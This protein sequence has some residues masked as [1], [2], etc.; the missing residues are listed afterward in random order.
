[1]STSLG[2][3]H[4]STIHCRLCDASDLLS[5]W[6]P[7]MNKAPLKLHKPG[8]CLPSLRRS[9]GLCSRVRRDFRTACFLRRSLS[10]RSC[11][12]SR[13]LKAYSSRGPWQWLSGAHLNDRGTP[14]CPCCPAGEPGFP[15]CQQLGGYKRLEPAK[16]NPGFS[17]RDTC[18][19]QA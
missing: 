13:A 12:K 11:F 7:N 2:D 9:W 14:V 4:E 17:R 16:L 19:L 8:W 3:R 10:D 5:G 18:A 6:F 15:R 1:M